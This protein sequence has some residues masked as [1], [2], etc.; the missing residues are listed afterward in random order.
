M[1]KKTT[2]LILLAVSILGAYAWAAGDK[3]KA[4]DVSQAFSMPAFS[5]SYPEPPYRFVNREFLIITYETDMEALKK[6]VPA[7]LEV[8]EPIVK[9]EFIRMPN[10]SGLGDYTESGQ[11]IPVT[12]KGKPGLYTLSMFLDNDPAILAGREIWGYPKKIASPTFGVD[13]VSRD[14]LVGRLKYGQ[15]DVAIG[16]MGYKFKAI[17]TE[18]VK[19]AIEETPIYLLKIIPNPDGTTALRQL[20]RTLPVNVTVKEAWTGPA[21]LQLFHHAMAPVA[22]LPVKRIISATH[23]ICDLSLNGGEIAYDYLKEK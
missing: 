12:F 23:F 4:A 14:T 8:T 13:P 9:Y 2:I 19:K 21:D 3:V 18:S 7:P 20:I 22:D 6:L 15:V 1:I 17:D 5:P 10:S 16:T 11:V